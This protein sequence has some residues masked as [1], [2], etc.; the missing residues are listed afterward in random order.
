MAGIE[1]VINRATAEVKQGDC[2]QIEL[3]G[4]IARQHNSL[5]YRNDDDAVMSVF[6]SVLDQLI[7]SNA[8]VMDN[9]RLEIVL[10]IVQDNSSSVRRKMET[11]LYGEIVR[12]KSRFLYTPHNTE[13][14]LCFAL[15]VINLLNPSLLNDQTVQLARRLQHSTG[16]DDQTPSTFGHVLKFEQMLDQKTVI[17]FRIEKNPPHLAV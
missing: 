11:L 7:Q 13:N 2:I 10:Q 6:Q 9:D 3:I 8:A 15:S 5:I 16:L 1:D 17:L 12:K 4:E 14:Q